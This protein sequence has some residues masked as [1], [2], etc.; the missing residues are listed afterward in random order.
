MSKTAVKHPRRVHT[1]GVDT[2]VVHPPAGNPRRFQRNHQQ[3]NSS[4]PRT[5][6]PDSRRAEVSPEAIGN[7]LLRAIDNK[8]ISIA[9]GSRFDIRDIRTSYKKSAL[10]PP[11]P[12]INQDSKLT[13]RLRNPQTKPRPPLK[14]IRQ[15]PPLLL[16]IPEIDNR[17]SSNRISTSK[18]PDHAQVATAR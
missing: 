16:L 15:K 13:I 8:M 18:R 4:P 17:W 12:S 6:S 10:K 1:T 11:F 9:R 2:G 14:H 7:P 5:T 3:A